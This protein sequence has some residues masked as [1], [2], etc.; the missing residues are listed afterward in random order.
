MLHRELFGRSLRKEYV[1]KSSK[2]N[3][4]THMYIQMN[5]HRYIR[6]YIEINELKTKKVLNKGDFSNLDSARTDRHRHFD[7]LSNTEAHKT[8]FIAAKMTLWVD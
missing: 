3:C 2:M 1:E 8:Y 6:T 5:I 4:Y 7:I